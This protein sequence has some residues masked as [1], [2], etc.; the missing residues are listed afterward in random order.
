MELKAADW[1]GAISSK[2][3][4]KELMQASPDVSHLYEEDKGKLAKKIMHAAQANALHNIAL[5]S[6]L[7]LE[8]VG[9]PLANKVT[10]EA[11]AT[12]SWQ[13]VLDVTGWDGKTNKS[14]M[15]EATDLFYVFN[16]SV[17][18]IRSFYKGLRVQVDDDNN[19]TITDLIGD[20]RLL[21]DDLRFLGLLQTLCEVRMSALQQLITAIDKCDEVNVKGKFGEAVGALTALVDT[22][23]YELQQV[24]NLLPTDQTLSVC[25]EEGDATVAGS[26]ANSDDEQ[27]P[28]PPPPEEDDGG[29][30]AQPPPPPP[31]DHVQGSSGEV[32]PPPPEHLPPLHALPQ[33]PP[34]PEIHG[35]QG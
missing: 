24:L 17:D 31:P 23:A 1:V 28:P 15:E 18:R 11:G 32:H 19:L 7:R 21:V 13:E 9:D 2:C 20:R 5:A 12:I 6:Y 34:T 35:K 3:V 30:G 26:Q 16:P 27:P 8:G 10:I 29:Q 25:V 14:T 22:E 33:A 4:A